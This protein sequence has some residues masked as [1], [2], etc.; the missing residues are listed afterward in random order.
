MTDPAQPA[1]DPSLVA[2][3]KG[4]LFNPKAEW[5]IIDNEFATTQ[6]LF[7]KYAVLLAAIGPVCGLVASIVFGMGHLGFV[8]P[9]VAAVLGYGLNLLVVFVVGLLID[10]LAP[11]FGGQK[12]KIQA[13]KVSVYSNT[14]SWIGGVFQLIPF[15]GVLLS[16]IASLYSLYLLYLG[17]APLMKAPQDKAIGYT[18]VVILIA[19]VAFWIALSIVGMVTASFLISSAVMGGAI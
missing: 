10:A 19:I 12:N 9:I 8:G 3:V 15:L 6:T 2:R 14:A 4:L 17:L 11:S 7:T 16:L 5:A 18:V 13:M 1:L